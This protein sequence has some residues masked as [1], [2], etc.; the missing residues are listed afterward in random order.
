MEF[1][2]DFKTKWLKFYL[3]FFFFLEI[4]AHVGCAQT[5]TIPKEHIPA[6]VDEKD[7]ER[8]Y[9]TYLS[10]A[11]P[12]EKYLPQGFLKNGSIDYTR[13]VQRCLDENRVV[14][15]PDFPI[16]VSDLGLNIKSN[17]VLLFKPDSRIILSA[18]TKDTYNILNIER[19]KNVK[20]FHPKIQGDLQIHKGKGGE[21]GMGIGIR[22]S[23][24]IK[25][26]NAHIEDCWGDGIYVGFVWDKNN[27]K[28]YPESKNIVIKNCV[29]NRSGRNGL[30]I[31]AVDGIQVHNSIFA[32]SYRTF[33][34]A[35]IDIEPGPKL[36]QGILLSNNVTFRND[37]RGIDIFLRKMSKLRNNTVSAKI[38]N[39]T[40]I[41]SAYGIRIAGYKDEKN[42]FKVGGDITIIEPVFKNNKRRGLEIEENQRFAPSITVQNVSDN[43]K[44]RFSRDIKVQQGRINR[45]R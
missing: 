18:S 13:Y 44:R 31:V 3:L 20:I 19:V 14:V 43:S 11:V 23:E 28:L 17:S 36:T 35:G 8:Q 32:N 29:V 4:G 16:R 41:E 26:F 37:A 27:D 24:N 6:F 7:I 45:L 42:S 39:H 33:P 25:V 21:W 30:S 5:R 34:K 9:S 10:T 1:L 2:K 12:I 15:F 40:D 38:I 22:S